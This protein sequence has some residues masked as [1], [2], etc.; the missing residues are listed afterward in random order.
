MK[1][2][3][4]EFLWAFFLLAI[5]III[6]LFNFRK[7]KTIYFSNISFLKEIKE[8]TKSKSKLKHLLIL[9][10]RL[11][12]LSFL[13][14]AFAK[15]YIPDSQTE[16]I[17]LTNLV[18]IYVD[19]SFSMNASGD[20]GDLLNMAKEYSES[21]I[22]SYS[23]NDRFQIITNDLGGEQRR[24]LTKQEAI[25]EL[26][27]I[28][29]SPVYRSISMV[30]GF[31]NEALKK[32][33]VENSSNLHYYWVSDFQKNSSDFEEIKE[34]G[35]VNILKLNA[36]KKSNLFVDSV[37][38]ESPIS[39]G[40]TQLEL[41]YRVQNSSDKDL[42][43][44]QVSLETG[45]N[46]REMSINIIANSFTIET[47]NFVDNAGVGNRTGK[48]KVDDSQIYYDDELYFSYNVIDNVKVLILNSDN[49]GINYLEKL[50]GLDDYYQFSSQNINHVSQEEIFKNDLIILNNTDFI[51]TGISK[52]LKEF[53][54]TGGSIVLIPGKNP[55]L[56]TLNEFV[57]N[58]D[59]PTYITS[60]S[61]K[62]RLSKINAEDVLFQGVFKKIPKN[63]NL[64][65]INKS[66]RF[67]EKN[68]SGYVSVVDFTNGDP[69]FIRKIGGPGKIYLSAVPLDDKFSNFPKHSLFI[70]IFLRIGEMSVRNNQLFSVIG[71]QSQYRFTVHSD[72]KDPVHL[73]HQ[74]KT[75]DIIPYSESKWNEELIYLGKGENSNELKQGFYDVSKGKEKLG[76]IALNFDRQESILEFYNQTE[77][78]EKLKE[79]G[80]EVTNFIDIKESSENF[81][82]DLNK[83]KEYWRILLILGLIFILIEILL[84]KFLKT[85]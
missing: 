52:N 57:S 20:N 63:I 49:Q 34:T 65:E 72:S 70:S 83:S 47:F 85:N 39:K 28:E 21:I 8:E 35:N 1:F 71:E 12:A 43:N 4:P 16:D 10:S 9:I 61:S 84:I 3:F 68:S 29:A 41:K 77:I 31:Q 80:I 75:I 48:I 79:Q 11:L 23:N 76:V 27:K 2:A 53:Y 46:S 33:R 26:Y 82:I 69:F 30:Y 36:V 32:E 22:N 54:N 25:E 15:P 55:Q 40:H 58:F 6:H 18:S 59:L 64:P 7:F 45:N 44:I 66:Y 5:P 17:K 37:W 74:D 42:E 24:N 73:T 60:D 81:K 14:L 62:I 78:E 38:F 51:S 67:N 19:N 56:T 13:I 50:Y